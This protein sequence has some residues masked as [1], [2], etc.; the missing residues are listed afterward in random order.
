MSTLV[1]DAGARDAEHARAVRETFG[2]IAGT[3]D[4]LNRMMSWGVDVRWRRRAVAA[5]ARE[6]PE[7]VVVDLCA[8]TLDL[9]A[10][11]VRV[12]P[13]RQVLALDF[14]REMLVAG[15]QKLASSRVQVGVADAMRLPLADRSVAGLVCGFGLRNLVDARR[16][17][18]E[19][20]RVVKP[21][22]VVVLLEF[23]RPVRSVTRAFHAVYAR[24]VL[25][26][27]G[28]A[29]SGDGAAYRYLAASMKGFL[30]R[31]EVESVMVEAGLREVSGADLTLGIASIVR[32][33][34]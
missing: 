28:G 26:V 12:M 20:H 29:V 1:A 27:V 34:A 14:A 16:G 6:L 2:R 33:V 21:G 32:G 31:E 15:R 25:P 18:A 22:G 4:A 11:I 13:G 24:G 30:A 8:G 19:M 5:L 7:G 10:E 17:I 23:F 3:Y 9:T